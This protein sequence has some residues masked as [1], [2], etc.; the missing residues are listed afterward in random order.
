[1]LEDIG[2]ALIYRALCW[3]LLVRHLYIEAKSIMLEAI[4]GAPI[5]IEQCVGGY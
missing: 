3:G 5:Y 4:G 1:M 2:G